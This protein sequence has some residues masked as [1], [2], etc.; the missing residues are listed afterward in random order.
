MMINAT[1]YARTHA[2]VAASLCAA[3]VRV[4]PT[5]VA[6][7]PG[8]SSVLGTGGMTTAR[9]GSMGWSPPS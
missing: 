9:S 4:T 8:K 7:V 1:A 6:Q 3:R 2:D 5:N